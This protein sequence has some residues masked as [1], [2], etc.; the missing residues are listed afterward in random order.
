V[1]EIVDLFRQVGLNG[2]AHA[3]NEPQFRRDFR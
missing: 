3:T 1:G 2:G